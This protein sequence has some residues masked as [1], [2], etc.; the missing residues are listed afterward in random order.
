M[1]RS[2]DGT[3]DGLISVGWAIKPQLNQKSL[4]RHLGVPFAQKKAV[5]IKC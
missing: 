5:N 2:N 3:G 1:N 4:L